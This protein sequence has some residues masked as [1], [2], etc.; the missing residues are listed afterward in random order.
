MV[1]YDIDETNFTPGRGACAAPNAVVL[2]AVRTSVAEAADIYCREARQPAA[3]HQSMHVIVDAQQA[4]QFVDYA[5]TAKAFNGVEAVPAGLVPCGTADE[6]TINVGINWPSQAIKD[7][8]NPLQSPNTS[9]L[10]KVLA[11]VF[12]ANSLTPST[13][14]LFAAVGELP[15]LDITKLIECVT[16]EMTPK[17]VFIVSTEFI[18][19]S[20][21][22]YHKSDGTF[23]DHVL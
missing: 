17:R 5:D 16:K 19:P 21:I 10:C 11:G 3:A 4:A 7:L 18:D 12:T 8:C 14:T 13:A 2:H 20:T 23:V 9:W 15:D 22:R 6:G 1:V